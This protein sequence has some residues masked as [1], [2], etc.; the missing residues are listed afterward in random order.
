MALV[1]MIVV[2]SL[3]QTTTGPFLDPK[4]TGCGKIT[5]R[6]RLAT[7]ANILNSVYE[8]LRPGSKF[9]LWL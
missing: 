4:R 9:D 8:I 6:R 5:E 1:T 3:G 2:V 7:R